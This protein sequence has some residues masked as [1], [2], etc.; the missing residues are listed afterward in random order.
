M[1]FE[2]VQ[3]SKIG[4]FTTP[5][6]DPQQN[7]S[8][9]KP[10]DDPYEIPKKLGI[11]QT[12]QSNYDLSNDVLIERLMKNREMYIQKYLNKA[13]KDNDFF[14]QDVKEEIKEI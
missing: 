5:K 6:L 14:A 2:G 3:Y 13:K 7:Y 10:E 1:V 11:Y 12:I 8:D 9:I 4:N